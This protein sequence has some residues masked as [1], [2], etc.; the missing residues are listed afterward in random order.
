MS[1]RALPTALLV[2]LLG[3][4]M[5]GAL[6][7]MASATR[8]ATRFDHLFWVLLIIQGL[9]LTL[10]TVLIITNLRGLLRKLKR[11]DPGSRLTLRMVGMFV[12]LSVVPALL[13]YGFSLDFL[14]RGVDSW[15][16]VE[17]EAALTD[18]LDLSKYALDLRMREHLTQLKLAANEITSGGSPSA[19]LD[20]SLLR[21]PDA[22]VISNSWDFGAPELDSLRDRLGAEELVM[23]SREGRI[24]GASSTLGDFVPSQP[25]G[26]LML[27]IRQGRSYISLEPVPDR[28]LVIQAGVAIKDPQLAGR[29][30]VLFALFPVSQRPNELASNIQAAFAKYE[31][32]VYLRD[33]LK[34]SFTLILTMVLVFG[35]SAAVLAAFYSARRLAAP[36]HRLADGTRSVAQGDYSIRIAKD[37]RDDFGVLVDSFNDMT[38]QLQS[39]QAQARAS[40]DALEQQHAYLAAVLG[41]LSSGVMTVSQDGKL[42]TCN[43]VCNQILGIDLQTFVGQPLSEV[44]QNHVHLEPFVHEILMEATRMT[45]EWQHEVVFFGRAGRQHVMCRGVTLASAEGDTGADTVVVFDDLTALVQGQRDAAWSEVAR[46]LA[47]EI[48]NPLTPIQLSAERLR[49]KYLKRLPEDEQEK[50]GR[51]TTTIVQQVDA[52]KGM[53]NTFSDYARPPKPEFDEVDLNELVRGVISLYRNS[54]P[55]PEFDVQ[56]APTLPAVHADAARLRQVLNNLV[57][58]AIEAHPEGHT[59]K[60]RITTRDRVD[61]HLHYVDLEI[62][63]SGVGLSHEPDS[64]IFAPYVTHKEKGTGLGLAIVKKIA[65]EHGGGVW[66]ENRTDG[67][68]ALAVVRLPV[69]TNESNESVVSGERL[70]AQ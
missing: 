33:K 59:P 32:L 44:E 70:S 28:G 14:R 25:P 16:D 5:L 11:D 9:G 54:E 49:H 21:S 40:R 50:F 66:M 8:N 10:F 45:P 27:Q 58:N 57:K 56:L 48:K 17:T 52:M 62:A 55:E 19:P 29:D 7:L 64:D 20:L 13:I 34:L 23:L 12:T 4:V 39:A 51:L 22:T 15:F 6:V 63:D 30:R 43:P 26:S 37:T 47:H 60:I 67:P 68:G 36:I 46:R 3:M 1:P 41:N 35:L 24:L 53:V 42:R 65:E 31:R 61:D 18:A 2:I 38:M 69:R